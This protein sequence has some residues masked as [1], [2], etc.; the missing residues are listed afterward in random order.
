MAA[1]ASIAERI[2]PI[3]GVQ[4]KPNP[5]PTRK[6]LKKGKLDLTGFNFFST[7]RNLN[8]NIP[9]RCKERRIIK[10]PA[11]FSRINFFSIK[12]DPIKDEANPRNKKIVEKPK[13]NKRE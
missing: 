1:R 8:L 3:H 10:I 6:D 5:N 13:T 7:S 9:I 11:T 4:P 2:G 12:K